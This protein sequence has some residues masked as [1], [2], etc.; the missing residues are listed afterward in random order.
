MS[1]RAIGV[2]LMLA[3][4]L[5]G[6]GCSAPRRVRLPEWDAARAEHV[7][8]EVERYFA[9]HDAGRIELAILRGD[10]LVLVGGMGAVGGW[11]GSDHAWANSRY[12]LDD[13]E[14]QMLA[15]AALV[16]VD[17]GH[18]A[19]DEQLALRLAD[20]R[21]AAPTLRELLHQVSGLH[22]RDSTGAWVAEHRPRERWTERGAHREAATEALEA[23]T[24][25]SV[26]ALMDD[27]WSRA[28]LPARDTSEWNPP[29]SASVADL[30]RWARALE[31]GAVVSRERYAEM[32][33]L[34][35]LRD[36][37]EWPYGMGLE[38]QTFEGRAKVMHAASTET[39]T[40][41][42]ARYPQDDLSIALAVR[43]PHAWSLPALERR[44]ARRVLGAPDPAH[45]EVPI[46]AADLER[47]VGAYACGELSFE[48]AAREGRLTLAVSCGAGEAVQVPLTHIGGGRYVSTAEPDAVHVWI[49]RGNGPV[50]ELV[51]G[52]FGLPCQALRR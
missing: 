50:P 30:A 31:Q 17:S 8:R 18:I 5:A 42:L 2:G 1:A 22:A 39:T 46:R 24:G 16:Q 3:V 45:A 10:S 41:V 19:L 6:A 32:T 49:K 23:Q 48:L 43:A 26:G 44:I 4:L 11:V 9:A 33:R 47:A 38:L 27:V 14:R 12:A 37:R 7:Q 29:R 51:I 20:D 15:A 34:V 36:E 21:V 52:W 25:R 28:G 35:T 40:V 13:L